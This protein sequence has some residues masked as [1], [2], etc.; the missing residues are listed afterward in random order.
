[1]KY[2]I[3]LASLCLFFV[4]CK[5]DYKGA[6]EVQND[7]EVVTKTK[8][9]KG[10]VI[11]TTVTVPA[12]EYKGKLTGSSNS[13][14]FKFDEPIKV[15]GSKKNKSLKKLTVKINKEARKKLKKDDFT[16]SAKETNQNFAVK[17]NRDYS[18]TTGGYSSGTQSC[19][20]YT[21]S[22][23]CGTVCSNVCGEYYVD[24]NGV[25]RRK[26]WK[27]CGNE[28]WQVSHPHPGTQSYES[29][30]EYKKWTVKADILAEDETTVLSSLAGVIN[31]VS[32]KSSYGSCH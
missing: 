5:G 26:C 9:K 17:V 13:L 1:M 27:S 22:T 14:V 19:T 30:T 21:Y 8:K 32:S 12:G 15:Q 2:T 11:Q 7:L 3:L 24:E 18:L 31:K 28:C 10:K 25:K 4:G 20:W 29:W 16:L 23:Q 6:L